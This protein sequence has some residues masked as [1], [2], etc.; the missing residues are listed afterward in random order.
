MFEGYTTTRGNKF[1]EKR[2]TS[3]STCPRAQKPAFRRGPPLTL[4]YWLNGLKLYCI[5]P[6]LDLPIWTLGSIAVQTLPNSALWE[7]SR[8]FYECS[9]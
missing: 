2:A 4:C 9:V 7:E 6:R 5:R 8:W 3:E 1:P